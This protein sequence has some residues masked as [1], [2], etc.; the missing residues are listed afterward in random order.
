MEHGKCSNDD[1]GWWQ[2]RWG[3]LSRSM[4]Q[5]M[6]PRKLTRCFVSTT[7]WQS[8]H[9]I[10]LDTKYNNSQI[11]T[12]DGFGFVKPPHEYKVLHEAATNKNELHKRRDLPTQRAAL[13]RLAKTRKSSLC[14]TFRGG[15]TS[16]DLPWPSAMQNMKEN[17]WRSGAK[18]KITTPSWTVPFVCFGTSCW[19]L[20]KRIFLFYLAILPFLLVCCSGFSPVCDVCVFTNGGILKFPSACQDRELFN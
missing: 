15:E 16:L 4:H 1:D 13:A 20:C 6:L 12:K 14:L 2:E 17:K 5:K 8:P 10:V 18:F 19:M 9:W 11:N 3:K 7:L